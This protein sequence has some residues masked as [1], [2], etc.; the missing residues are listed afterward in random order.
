VTYQ[1]YL[2]LG[3]L[4]DRGNYSIETVLLVYSL[5]ICFPKTIYFL[6]GNHECREM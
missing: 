5:K 2:F 6:R 1:R 3:D 4:V